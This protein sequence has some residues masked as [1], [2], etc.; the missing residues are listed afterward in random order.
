MIRHFFSSFMLVLVGLGCAF[1]S[2]AFLAKTLSASEYGVFS[3]I[4]SVSLLIGVFSLFGFQN[5]AVKIISIFQI[6]SKEKN[7]TIEFS[8]FSLLYCVTLAILMSSVVYIALA[9]SGLGAQYS[10]QSMLLGFFMTP[11]MVIMRLHSAFLRGLSKSTLS[12]LFETSL[13]EI[14]FLIILVVV[15]I[16]GFGLETGFQA[17]FYLIVALF[18]SSIAAWLTAR[19][20]FKAQGYSAKK[21]EWVEKKE[22]LKLSFP[23]MLIIFAQRLLRRSDIIILGLMTSPALVGAYAIAAQFSEASSIGQKG[24]FAVFSPKAATLHKDGKKQALQ[25]LYRKMQWIGIFST[26]S[27]CLFIVIVAPYVLDFFGADYKVAYKSTIILLVGMFLNVC[28]GPVGILMIMTGREKEAM[29]QTATMAVANIIINPIAIYFYGMEGAAFVTS[30]LFVYR[31]F[32]NY[33]DVKKQ[34]II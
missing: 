20:H 25:N 22:W 9:L 15:F 26:G 21:T 19:H 32:T 29:R 24:V 5:A 12:V 10:H 33:L 17:L 16:G 31:G 1:L 8:R 3:F 11:L 14:L 7:K 2:Q 34:G 23:M 27:L 18:I 6:E 4:F 28:F 13:R 30:V